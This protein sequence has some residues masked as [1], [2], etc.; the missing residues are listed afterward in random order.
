MKRICPILFVLYFIC[1]VPISAQEWSPLFNGKNL[2]GWTQ[3]GG[4]ATY[5]VKDGTI[6]GYS[7]MN[8]DNSFLCTEQDYGDFILEFDFMVD[9]ALN[10]GVQL[11]S[12]SLPTYQNGRVHG[13]QFEIDPAP[14]SWTGGIYDEARRGW[15]YPMI[16]NSSAQ[17]AFKNKEWNH[18]RVEAV[19]KSIR[20]FV[21]GIPCAD[22]YDT[23]D[24]TGFI[25]LQVHSI[26]E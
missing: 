24:S 2:K 7:R 23:A 14:R 1:S 22:L 3:R 5:K 13:Y 11:R 8:T 4:K 15:L 18:A 6:V 12:H 19:G 21:N 25:A 17:T 20:T 26:R 10:S 16:R 9:D